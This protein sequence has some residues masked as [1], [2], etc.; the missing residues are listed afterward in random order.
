MTFSDKFHFI[1]VQGPFSFTNELTDHIF[2]YIKDNNDDCCWMM[3]HSMGN[4]L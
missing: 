3:H 2:V 4:T 1:N